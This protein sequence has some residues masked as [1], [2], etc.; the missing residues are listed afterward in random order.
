MSS[1]KQGLSVNVELQ[2]SAQFTLVCLWP[3]QAAFW[4]RKKEREEKRKKENKGEK[5]NRKGREMKEKGKRKKIQ[6][7][8]KER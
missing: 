1:R 3:Q 7:K 2:H 6:R 4:N 8:G 5:R